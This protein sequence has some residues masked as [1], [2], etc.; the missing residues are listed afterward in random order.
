MTQVDEKAKAT[1]LADEIESEGSDPTF[2]I[3]DDEVRE[4]I[5]KALRA[6]A[7]PGS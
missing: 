4:L 3:V 1:R 5:V 2:I 6:Y 7:R